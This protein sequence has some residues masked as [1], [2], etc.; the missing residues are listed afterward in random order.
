MSYSEHDLNQTLAKLFV[1]MNAKIT[2]SISPNPADFELLAH[3]QSYRKK[4]TRND[5]KGQKK[6]NTIQ[7][8]L[9][10]FLRRGKPWEK[11]NTPIPDVF[12]IKVP[13]KKQK[14]AV[15]HLVINHMK[16][17]LDIKT[18]QTFQR[19]KG[20]FG[21]SRVNSLMKEIDQVNKM[22]IHLNN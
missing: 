12:V 10:S 6:G 9:R 1:V 5:S 16:R 18:N 17:E 7:A 13:I 14:I 3:L 4:I 21:D 19:L 11:M 20:V 2:S 15:L 8:Q 22:K